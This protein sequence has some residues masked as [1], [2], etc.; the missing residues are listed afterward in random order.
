MIMSLEQESAELVCH[1]QE[2]LVG[3]GDDELLRVSGSFDEHA[4]REALARERGIRVGL[5]VA[6]R[7]VLPVATRLDQPLW[8]QR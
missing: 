4:L 8:K 7:H 5:E 2:T 1:S 6:D 3:C